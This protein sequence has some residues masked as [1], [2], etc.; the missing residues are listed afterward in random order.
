MV[1]DLNDNE[2][3]IDKTGD[4]KPFD[5]I[6]DFL[7][8]LFVDDVNEHIFYTPVYKNLNPQCVEFASNM[9]EFI[10]GLQKQWPDD[11]Y[12]AN[13]HMEQ[14]IKDFLRAHPK[15]EVHKKI[16]NI[17]AW[18]EAMNKKHADFLDFRN[19]LADVAFATYDYCADK[20][21]AFG[22]GALRVISSMWDWIKEKVSNI[23]WSETFSALVAALPEYLP[24]IA[25]A[26]GGGG[27]G[28][29]IAKVG[30]PAVMRMFSKPEEIA[31]LCDTLQNGVA[32]VLN[33]MDHNNALDK[34]DDTLNMDEFINK[35][36]DIYPNLKDQIDEYNNIYKN[37]PENEHLLFGHEKENK[38]KLTNGIIREF[39]FNYEKYKNEPKKFVVYIA[40]YITSIGR[41]Q[42]VKDYIDYL[43]ADLLVFKDD[44]KK[45]NSVVEKRKL[46]TK[47]YDIKKNTNLK[48]STAR[49]TI[50]P[51]I[52]KSNNNINQSKLINSLVGVLP[53]NVNKD[54]IGSV[55]NLVNDAVKFKP[56]QPKTSIGDLISTLPNGTGNIINSVLQASP[57]SNFAKKTTIPLS[58]YSTLELGKFMK[59]LCETDQAKA[60]GRSM[61]NTA[62]NIDIKSTLK[63]INNMIPKKNPFDKFKGPPGSDEDDNNKNKFTFGITKDELE[64]KGAYAI[65]FYPRRKFFYF[66]FLKIN[67]ILF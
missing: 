65:P 30:I 28:V 52:D 17:G 8:Y 54:L 36:K 7:N 41:K 25:L 23:D 59:R 37:N 31:P 61:I 58:L 62:K 20:V 3:F 5:P 49:L 32:H 14:Y 57:L 1:N 35:F 56:E 11:G 26:L 9:N 33:K 24:Y 50:H 13:Y 19:K 29:G 4:D 46:A 67:L 53:N 15:Y 64:A 42:I 47:G 22:S 10:M 21:G 63:K 66:Y 43:E 55:A 2:R 39:D 27:V 16:N 40:N 38:R 18:S 34:K 48:D 6:V 12:N 45:Y 51:P 44:K 60:L